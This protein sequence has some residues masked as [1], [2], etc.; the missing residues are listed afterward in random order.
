M[1]KRTYSTDSIE[2]Y[3][4]SE[5]CIHSGRCLKALP[6]VFD[7]RVRPWV[8]VEAASADEIGAAIDTCPTGALMYARTDGAPGEALP[9]VTTIVPK[10]NGPNYVR[11]SLEVRDAQGETFLVG[12][13][14]AL[15]RCGA[16]ENQPF[17]DRSHVRIRFRDTPRVVAPERA[18]AESPDDG[19]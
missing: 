10:P 7:T 17:C 13:R 18:E 4:N 9:P 11:G 6:Q 15:C 2:V 8:N 16:S 19:V 3:W 14:A 12:P 1:A 5:L